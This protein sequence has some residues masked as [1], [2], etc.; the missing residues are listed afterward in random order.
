MSSS[1]SSSVRVVPSASS[2]GTWSEGP[3]ASVSG[4]S[5]SGIL[6]PIDAKSQRVLEVMKSCH[7]V[8]SV[9]GEEALGP[10]RECYSIPEEYVLRAPLV[11][12][13]PYNVGSSEISIL[14]DA[15][16]A[17]LHF[18]LHPTIVEC[19]RC[20]GSERPAQ[21]RMSSEK[22][23][24]AARARSSPPKVEEIRVETTTKRPVKS[25]APDQAT[26]GRPRKWVKIAVR[27]HK[28][29]H[30]EGSSRRAAREMELAVQVEEGLSPSYTRL[31]SMKDFLGVRQGVL[32]PTLANDLYTLPSEILMAQ[33]AKQMALGHHY[34]M[35]LL[36]RV[37]D[38][39]CLV[40]LMGN[41]AS[42]LEAEI[43]KLKME[44]DPEQQTIAWQQVVELQVDNAKLRSKLEELARQSE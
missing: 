15:L 4:S 30:G 36:D 11:E 32:H 44:G 8:V 10:I 17:D 39:G 24:S 18:P 21:P 3:E 40:T 26:A 6:S 35:T 33:A 13:R 37:H 27:K 2:K 7:N 34:Q 14:M 22:N 23:T 5:S 1:D 29:H 41:R 28:S 16:E 42:H 12:H 9:I 43:T 38:A 31:R 25:L 19:L 20:H